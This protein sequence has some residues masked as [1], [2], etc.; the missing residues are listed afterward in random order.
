MNSEEKNALYLC[1]IAD[2]WIR[3]AEKLHVEHAIKPVYFVHWGSESHLIQTADIPGCHFQTLEDAWKGKGFPVESK[4]RALDEP[5]IK[6]IAHYELV[7]LKMMDRL[8]PTGSSFPFSIR[9]YFLHELIG[10]WLDIVESRNISVIISPSIPHRVF[11]YALYIACKLKDIPFLMFQSLPFGSRSI[12]IDDID[13]MPPLPYAIDEPALSPVTSSRVELA[14]KNYTQAIPTYMVQHAQKNSVSPTKWLC[15]L[16]TRLG[17]I[18]SKMRQ[19]PSTYWV[20]RCVLPQQTV[21]SWPKLY[22]L[23]A[24]RFMRVKNMRIKYEEM[25]NPEPPDR[26]ILFALHYQ[27][28][29][30]SCPTGGLYFDQVTILRLLDEN[31]PDGISILVKEHK[32]QFYPHTESASGRDHEFYNV[33]R[34]ISSRVQFVSADKDPFTLIDNAIATVTISGTIGWE[35]A[36]R[37]T[38]TF[39]FGRAWYE[40]MPR[41]FKIKSKAALID[42]I[43][44]APTLKN[45]DLSSEIYDFHTRLEQASVLAKHYKSKA[46]NEDVTSEDSI[47]N[48]VDSIASHTSEKLTYHRM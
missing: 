10:V 2:P 7:A 39:V 47:R 1:A 46:L 18:P 14:L 15:H 3:V 30:T 40:G 44:E 9:V 32:S 27:P 25:A 43:K 37:G 11:D 41:V 21:I 5:T 35:S 16:F 13:S 24:L 22:Y 6:E 48:L 33:M 12:V 8:D 20:D 29:E 28:E 42:A 23:K 26:Y 31:L 17:K 19:V 36:V 45:T 4:V 38:P 34:R